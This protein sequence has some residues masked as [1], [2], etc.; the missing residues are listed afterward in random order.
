MCDKVVDD[1]SITLEFVPDRYKSMEMCDKVISENTFMLKYCPDKYI[2][3]KMCDEAV[4][5]FLPTLN[6]VPDWFVTNKVIKKLFTALY[7]DENIPY[8][9]EDFSNVVYNCNEMCIL[10]ID[11]NNINLDNNFDEDDPGTITHVRILAWH[12]KFEKRK[13]LKKNKN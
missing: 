10:N 8:F 5:D 1:Y 3:Q 13:E 12:I 6:F 9:D 2:T 4:D 11:L 7:V